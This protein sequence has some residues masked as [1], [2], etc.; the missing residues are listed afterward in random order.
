M[1]HF[2]KPTVISYKDNIHKSL[3]AKSYVKKARH[4]MKGGK[5]HSCALK[6]SQ[7]NNFSNHTCICIVNIIIIIIYYLYVMNYTKPLVFDKKIYLF[8]L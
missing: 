7:F 6:L 1:E 4:T 5:A 2:N 8:I 3:E